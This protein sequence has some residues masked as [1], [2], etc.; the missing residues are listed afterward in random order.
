[1]ARTTDYYLART[2]HGST[3]SRVVHAWVLARL[4]R[5][6]SW[7]TFT[8]AL[9]SDLDDT[10]G[11]TTREG[12]HLGVA[13]TVDLVLRGYTGGAVH[14]DILWFDPLL[15][16]EVECIAFE[17]FYRGQ[18]LHVDLHPDS[19][20]LVLHP[21]VAAP[22]HV[23]VTGHRHTLVAGDTYDLPIARTNSEPAGHGAGPGRLA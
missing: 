11:G 19:L 6:R 3:L 16:D 15:P 18:W 10:Q 14:D 5:A 23:D 2:V 17:L 21:C 1:M 9:R 12:I 4:D 22:I 8:D 13:G 7:S 20:R